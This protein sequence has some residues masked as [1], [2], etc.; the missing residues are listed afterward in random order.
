MRSGEASGH[1]VGD[2]ATESL[3]AGPSGLVTAVAIG[4]CRGESVV[5]VGVAVGASGDFT[6]WRKLMGAGERPTSG[7]VIEGGGGPGNGV[8]AGGAI[9]SGEWSAG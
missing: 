2:D 3:R 9:G 6:G 7:A 1:V 4:I 8:V 5:V